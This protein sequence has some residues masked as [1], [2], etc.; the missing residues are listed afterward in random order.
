MKKKIATIDEKMDCEKFKKKFHYR[1]VTPKCCAN[2][3]FVFADYDEVYECTFMKEFAN[4]RAFGL[5]DKFR[6]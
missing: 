3:F 5:C 4:T 1:D 2:C 6:K